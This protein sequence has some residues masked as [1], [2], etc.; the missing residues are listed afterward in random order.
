MTGAQLARYNGKRTR[1][2]TGW[3]GMAVCV[4]AGWG[5][6]QAG[7]VRGETSGRR[8]P[9]Q[10]AFIAFVVWLVLLW[11][12]P[13]QGASAGATGNGAGRPAPAGVRLS[14]PARAAAAGD[15]GVRTEQPPVYYQ[16]AVAVL[17]YHHLSST[18]RSPNTITPSLFREQLVQLRTSG[19]HVISLE[20]LEGFLENYETVPPNAVVLTFDDGYQSFYEEAF[21][22]L[23]EL[24]MT[25]TNFVVVGRV[26]IDVP[27]GQLPTLTWGQMFEME[28][29]GVARFESHT[30]NL[31]HYE[32]VGPGRQVP[33]LLARR[34][35]RDIGQLESTAAYRQRIYADLV[36]ARQL[37]E[38]RLGG[39]RRALAFPYGAYD[40]EAQMLAE[41]AG[42]AFLFSVEPGLVYRH[43]DRLHLPRINAG[44][45]YLTPGALIAQLRRWAAPLAM[46]PGRRPR[47]LAR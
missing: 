3:Q 13:L 10:A 35:E 44:A 36:A 5:R 19:F 4:A 40:P 12:A 32:M 6:R 25:A 2:W 39:P 41:M 34:W 18:F 38:E 11:A 46:H 22:V 29:T 23:Q 17:M 9:V 27:T 7:R 16:D 47:P 37:L 31:H 28:N 42:Y 20:Q 30:W 14:P 43:A 45:P 26:G 21:P 24:G 33:A 1:V 15:S 8:P